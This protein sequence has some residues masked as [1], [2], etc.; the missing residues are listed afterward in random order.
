MPDTLTAHATPFALD[1]WRAVEAQHKI[2]TMV[3]VDTLDEQ[4]LLESLLD[5]DYVRRIDHL[6][7]Q[8]HDF[9]ADAQQRRDAIQQRLRATHEL[10]Y[11]V[12]FVWESWHI[13]PEAR[14]ST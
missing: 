12:P 7:V 1:L 13:R 4:A 2:A 3:L 11:C 14:R 8:F 6:Q 9:F 5:H 10:D